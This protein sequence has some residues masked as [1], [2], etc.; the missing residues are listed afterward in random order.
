MSTD[1]I[2]KQILLRAT[3]SRVWRAL[4]DPDELAAWFGMRFEAPFVPGARL[5]GKIVG[6][7][8]DAEIAAAQRQHAHVKIDI[9]VERVE[10]EHVLSFR[11]HP[12]A[13]ERGVDYSQEARTLVEFR[14]E[15]ADG[16]VMLTVTES[17]FDQLS[18]TRRE[19]ARQ[20]NDQ[21][22]AIVVSLL[23][24]YVAGK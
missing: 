14:L 17:G 12:A 20:S 16:G 15:E 3:R 11:W 18:T 1:C 5:A 21:G 8:M 7:T 13:V 22:W 9:L 4:I 2:E 19:A 10:P 6:T 23:Q 24:R